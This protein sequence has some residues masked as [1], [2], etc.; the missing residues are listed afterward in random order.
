MF[1]PNYKRTVVAIY[2]LLAVA[3]ACIIGFIL[4]L[5]GLPAAWLNPAMTFAAVSV[6]VAFL[7]FP[8][9]GINRGIWRYAS[10][11][12]TL[13]IFYGATAIILI[14]VIIMFFLTRLHLV[15]RSAIFIS[16]MMI[17][18]LMAAPRFLLRAHRED[19]FGLRRMRPPL[20]GADISNVVIFGITDEAEAFLRFLN[21]R[22]KPDYNVLAIVDPTHRHW[23]TQLRGVPVLSLKGNLEQTLHRRDGDAALDGIILSHQGLRNDDMQMVLDY[24]ASKGIRVYRFPDRMPNP[25]EDR[26]LLEN[27]RIEDLL[28]RDP[29][30]VDLEGI[31]QLLE[32][33]TVLVTGC[34]GTIGSTLVEFIL[35]HSIGRLV[36]LDNSEL[37]IYGTLNLVRE[38]GHSDYGHYICSVTDRRRIDRII[39]TEKPDFIFHAAA[40]KHVDLV[41]ANPEEGVLVNV[42]GTRNVAD[43]AKR[44]G[45]GVF[46]LVST[47]KAVAPSS[48]MGACKRAAEG[49][50]Q[51]AN[52]PSE[53]GHVTRFVTVRFGNVLG[54]SGS[55]VPAFEKQINRGGP[56]TLTDPAVERYFMTADEA[57]MLIMHATLIATRATRFQDRICVLDMGEPVL[58]SELARQMILLSGKRPGEDIQ[59]VHTGLRP[60]EKLREE[61]IDDNEELLKGESTEGVLVVRCQPV[62]GLA[63]SESLLS[64]YK[65]CRRGDRTELRRRLGQLVKTATLGENDERTTTHEVIQ[66]RSERHITVSGD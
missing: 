63:Y 30:S 22:R 51:L 8:L 61:L 34:G 25:Y 17:I 19:A 11:R 41:E 45:V 59:I 9:I 32:G 58:I 20:S 5:D 15:P 4:R 56:V 66:P 42:F 1:R 23:G 6:S 54:S 2:D 39:K 36:L 29:A 12:D 50:V 16:W 55:V 40:L 38:N 65:A 52:M 10:L 26:R 44:H 21:R 14:A 57:R 62:D 37:G 64:L 46:V 28:Q 7:V 31:H 47:D 53:D 35:K 13:A 60:G 3:L 27:I 43:A 48:V 33:K 49:Y 24:A 18:L